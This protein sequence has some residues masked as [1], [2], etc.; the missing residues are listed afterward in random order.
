MSVSYDIVIPTAGRPALADLIEALTAQRG[1][2]PERVIVVD[3]RPATV[4]APLDLGVGTAHPNDRVEVLRGR[5]RGPAAARNFGWRHASAEWVVFLD[6]DV[7]PDPDWSER[8]ERDLSGLPA[9][10]AASQGRIHVPLPSRRRPTDRE[11]CV[12]GLETAVWATAD[13]A[14]R[15]AVLTELVGFDE[16]FPRA[17]REDADLG[18]RTIAAGYR[19]VTGSRRVVHP[20]GESGLLASVRLQAG[21]A[22]DV[23]MRALHGAGWREAAHAPSG[24]G[25]RHLGTVAAGAAGLL[26]RL[27]GNRALAVA[28]AATW[29]AATA[30]FAWARIAPGPR[31]PAEIGSMILT[32][33][34]IPPAAAFHTAKGVLALPAS[35]R[36]TRGRYDI[37]DAVLLDRD[38][39]LVIDVPYNGDPDAVEPMPGAAEALERLRAAGIETAVVSN[40]SGIGRGM[41]NR[42]SVDAVNRRIEQLLGPVGPWIV[43]PHAP[44]DGCDCRKP[45]PGLVLE[46]AERLGADPRRCAVIGDIGADVQAAR[47]AGARAILVPTPQTRYEEI[48]SAP[49]VAP[50]LPTAV[51]M[52]LGERAA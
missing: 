47:A 24:R 38:G 27:T 20:V 15:R 52:L 39:T 12:A 25:R 2:I 9:D 3:D 33:A 11:R 42:D 30:E 36:G 6:D 22:D 23:L 35:L 10:V 7:V 29:A 37:P 40:Q 46:A 13:M 41:L 50:D 8:V 34:L 51:D 21:N 17:Y 19:I 28:G 14:Y 49:E 4:S 44:D 45:A 32:S 31:T 18:L 26:G 43:C 48:V 5:S 1:T 16:R